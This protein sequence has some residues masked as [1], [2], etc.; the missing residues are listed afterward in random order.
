VAIGVVVWELEVVGAQSLK[1]KR[2]VLNSLKDRLRDRFR[3][4]VGETG[5][6]DLWQRAELT[7]CAVSATR[8]QTEKVL[9]HADDFVA[10]EPRVRIIDAGRSYF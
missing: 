9:Q 6:L 5:H 3:L 7:A 1:E 8:V 4:A 10:A 2:A